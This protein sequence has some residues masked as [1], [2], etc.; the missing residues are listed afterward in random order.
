LNGDEGSFGLH[1]VDFIEG[2]FDNIFRTGALSFPALYGFILSLTI[3]IFGQTAEGIRLNSAL[4]GALTVAALYPLAK[5]MFGQKTAL[6]AAIFLAGFHYHN[7]YS[8]MALN[9]IWDPLFFVLVLG[10][11]WDGWRSEKQ[12]SF[13]LA[14]VALGLSQYFYASARLLLVIV[15]AWILLEGWLDRQRLKRLLPS[16]LVMA[17]AAFVTALPLA[18]FYSRFPDEYRAPLVRATA[19][20]RWIESQVQ[21]TGWPAWWIWLKQAG[22]SFGGFFIKPLITFYEPGTP[23]LRLASAVLG[24]LGLGALARSLKKSQGRLLGLWLFSVGL[25]GMFSTTMPASQRYVA[26]APAVAILVGWGL[27]AL[28]DRAGALWPQRTRLLSVL[29]VGMILLVAVDDVRFFLKDYKEQGTIGGTHTM[30]AQ[31]LAEY[32]QQKEAGWEVV[33]FGYPQMGYRTINSLPYLAPQ[34]V[35]YTMQQPWG[36]GDNPQPAGSRLIFVFLPFREDDLRRVEAGYPNGA[37]KQEFAVDGSLLF[38]L[39]EVEL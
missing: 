2:R 5:K 13:V 6:F 32:L 31:R 8:R 14:G 18:W 26:A 22:L 15:P 1:A 30:V 19:L 24:V 9:N 29:G 23:M 17:L 37:L 10:L 4:A 38:W 33:F 39:Y 12:L 20:G 34:V 35:D 36:S 28:L 21:I 7:A 11:L 3:R 16:L 27:A 25:S